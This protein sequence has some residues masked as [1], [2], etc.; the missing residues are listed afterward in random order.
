[1]SSA[2]TSN[3]SFVAC[4]GG[5]AD[6]FASFVLGL[7]TDSYTTQVHATGPA[8]KKFTDR[9]VASVKPFSLDALSSDQEDEVA[10]K[11]AKACAKSAVVFTDV[12][13]LFAEKV[14]LAFT[15]YAPKVRRIAYYDN[16]EKYVPGGYSEVASKVMSHA[17]KVAFS[18]AKLAREPIFS[19]PGVEVDL[20][21]SR[22]IGIGYYPVAQAEALFA[23]RVSEHATCRAELFAKHSIRDQGQKVLVYFGGNNEEYFSKAFPAFVDFLTHAKEKSDLSNYVI[24]LQQHPGAKE[25][26][27]DGLKLAAW[28]KDH[29]ASAK[30]PKIIVSDFS[31]DTAQIVADGALYYQ[32]SMGPQFAIAGIPTV[33]VAH[34]TYEDILVRNNLCS[35]VTSGDELIAAIAQLPNFST[36]APVKG[37][38]FDALGI[39]QDW[40]AVLKKTI[41]D[42]EASTA[43]DALKNNLDRSKFTRQVSQIMQKGGSVGMVSTLKQAYD[44]KDELLRLACASIAHSILKRSD[45][46]IASFRAQISQD[47]QV[48]NLSMFRVACE[49][50][51]DGVEK[52][53][54]YPSPFF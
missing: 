24:V 37:P 27:I 54:T 20:P 41:F 33:Q 40:L 11:I 26:N 36:V 25:K 43:L 47:L 48:P 49:T 53:T 34:E 28:I 2:V 1:M 19:A 13:H 29:G 23:R 5:P 52:N 45:E 14:E 8:L 38:L 50:L 31:S 6:H 44:S 42:M 3:V 17:E 9:G 21:M 30:S 10:I 4:H 22:R 35:K 32:T 51:A 7:P 16:P 46:C 15:L 12:G 39:R 18:N